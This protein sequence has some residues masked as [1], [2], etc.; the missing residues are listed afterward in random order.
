MNISTGQTTSLTESI[1]SGFSGSRRVRPQSLSEWADEHFY[2]SPG[3]SYVAGPWK[4]LPYQRDIMDCISTDHIKTIDCLK[5]A[6]LGWTKIIV[7]AVLYFAEHKKRNTGLY[8]PSAKSASDFMK[9]HIDAGIRDVEQV[10]PLCPWRGKKSPHSTT[11][12]KLFSSG[13]QL[14]VLGGTAPRNYDEHTWDVVIYDELDRFPGNVGGTSKK[15][16]GSPLALGDKRIEGSYFP[17]SLRGTTPASKSDSLIARSVSLADETFYFEVPCPHCGKYQ[18]L[19]FGGPD[20]DFGLKWT[21]RDPMTTQ[22]LCKHCHALFDR[23]AAIEVQDQGIWW[24]RKHE[25]DVEVSAVQISRDELGGITFTDADGNETPT[26]EHVAFVIWSI[27]SHQLEWSDITKQFLAIKNNQEAQ[28]TFTNSTLGEVWDDEPED[29]IDTTLL[30]MRRE[31]YQAAVPDGVCVLTAGVDTQINRLEFEIVG[32]GAD[33]ESWSIDYG[34]IFG[35]PSKPEI[36]Q[37]LREQ[38]SRQFRMDDGTILEVKMVCHDAGGHFADQVKKFSRENDPLWHIPI[39]GRGDALANFPKKKNRDGVYLT[40]VGMNAS[41]QIVYQRWGIVEKGP[42][43][44]HFPIREDYDEALFR[45]FTAERH[46]RSF[47][48]GREIWEWKAGSRLNEASDCRRYAFAAI[49]ILQQHR[50]VDLNKLP[51]DIAEKPKTQPSRQSR[52]RTSR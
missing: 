17:K 52:Y 8:L 11:D 21:D 41:T 25:N 14:R 27:Y 13:K 12:L 48:S 6:R 2:L 19:E 43:Y 30:I 16:K 4:T 49:R 10:H 29:P 45:Q 34:R 31:K 51:T 23:Q 40:Y 47:K 22:Y 46:V 39:M 35:D 18:K 33:E 5:S 1:V 26:P 37:K 7:A 3:V 28:I 9:S 15:E 44:C 24:S 20:A 32:W 50:W 42:G 38:L 36:W